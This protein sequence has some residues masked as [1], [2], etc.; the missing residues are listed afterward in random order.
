[1]NSD[2]EAGNSVA[3]DDPTVRAS[4]YPVVYFKANRDVTEILVETL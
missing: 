3:P 1:M 4:V 2:R